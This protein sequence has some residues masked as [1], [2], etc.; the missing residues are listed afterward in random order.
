MNGSTLRPPGDA[1]QDRCGART[2]KDGHPCAR[3]P[4]TG[5]KRC[6]RHG[7][8]AEKAMLERRAALDAVGIIGHKSYISDRQAIQDALAEATGNIETFRDALRALASGDEAL[9]VQAQP[10][11]RVVGMTDD[12]GVL[13][14][15][16]L[17]AYDTE[18]DR[19]VAIASVAIKW[20]LFERKIANDERV[21]AAFVAYIDRIISDDSLNLTGD[22]KARAHQL[23]VLELSAG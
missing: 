11:F 5:G 21:S 20:G 6:Y 8:K 3:K 17:D 18:R 4:V 14:Q 15:R 2:A 13:A 22:Q 7:G 12:P 23:A 19:Q 1:A 10:A 9:I 16:L